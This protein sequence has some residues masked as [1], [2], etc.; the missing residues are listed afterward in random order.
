MMNN[1]HWYPQSAAS[2]GQQTFSPSSSGYGNVPLSQTSATTPPFLAAG[3]QNGMPA[4]QRPGDNAGGPPPP[5]EVTAAQLQEL[6]NKMMVVQMDPYVCGGFNRPGFLDFIY[7]FCDWT[8]VLMILL[9]L[10]SIVGM[11]II[12]GGKSTDNIFSTFDAGNT[13]DLQTAIEA[14]ISVNPTSCTERALLGSFGTVCMEGCMNAAT[15]AVQLSQW[16]N[17]RGTLWIIATVFSGLAVVYAIAIHVQRHPTEFQGEIMTPEMQMEFLRMTPAQQQ[18]FFFQLQQT[19]AQQASVCCGGVGMEVYDTPF[20]AF[21]RFAWGFCGLVV[22]SWSVNVLISFW[23][24]SGFY[25]DHTTGDLKDFWDS[26][27]SKFNASMISVLVFLAWPLV[28]FVLELV[29]WIIGFIPWL[30]VRMAAKPGIERFRPSLPLSSIPGYIRCDMFFMDFQDLKRLGFSRLQWM[31]L[32]DSERPFFDCLEDPTLIRDPDMMAQMLGG[33]PPLRQEAAAAPGGMPQKADVLEAAK[34]ESAQ[35]EG[36]KKDLESGQKERSASRHRRHRS[37]SVDGKSR[38]HRH[39]KSRKDLNESLGNVA[40]APEDSKSKKR[41]H[42]R[43]ESG[44]GR[45]HRSRSQS[46]SG[47]EAE[48]ESRR[49]HRSGSRRRRSGTGSRHASRKNT[50]DKSAASNPP[51]QPELD[52]LLQM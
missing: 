16:N 15:F 11:S 24:F 21:L 23:A 7:P 18:M 30:V 52:A 8:F 42:R 48:D 39:R 25:A 10:G 1:S 35:P 22:L 36:R 4:E 28:C 38:S 43:S 34:E 31:L 47:Q 46:R 19:M 6:Q 9:F 26:Y 41:R 2:T 12:L 50:E 14:L 3:T 5:P 44:T 20:Y 40:A 27:N 29:V 37:K 51:G 13:T 49:P 45:R 33:A 32:T 17:A